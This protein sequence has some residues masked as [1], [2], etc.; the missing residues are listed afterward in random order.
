MQSY[1]DVLCIN[2]WQVGLLLLSAVTLH[3]R[4]VGHLANC[5]TDFM[6]AHVHVQVKRFIDVYS[7]SSVIGFSSE[8]ISRI[9]HMYTQAADSRSLNIK[10]S[11]LYGNETQFPVLKRQIDAYFD[12]LESVADLARS[13]WTEFDLRV[14]AVGF[15]IMLTS[16]VIHFVAI[17]RAHD[18]YS[19]SFPS[20]GIFGISSG[21]VLA[22][23]VVAVRAC[24][25]L[26]NSYICK[27]SSLLYLTENTPFQTVSYLLMAFF[28]FW[29]LSPPTPFLLPLS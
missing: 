1:L 27:V 16:L 10:D 12:L 29:F 2:A 18:I 6:M 14:M 24:S 7:A 26:S 9:G 11:L 21:L 3:R 5:I 28:L 19:A 15:G 4:L 13:K 17:K 25:F 8:D 20:L 23:F 22:I